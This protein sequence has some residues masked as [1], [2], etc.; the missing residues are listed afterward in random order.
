MESS[1]TTLIST[2]L[3]TS[4]VTDTSTSTLTVGASAGFTPLASQLAAQGHTAGTMRKR[5][6]PN[7]IAQ[8]VDG[9]KELGLERRA[10]S[11]LK[12]PSKQ[13]PAAVSCYRFV[14]V[15]STSTVVSTAKT[16]KTV[17]ATPGTITIVSSRNH[18]E[19]ETLLHA[20]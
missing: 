17:T 18:D 6:A 2:E 1:T 12:R 20:Y 9:D 8:A 7:R 13:Y 3:T 11:G 14:Q 4:T 15:I 16:T 19:W 5:S 10:A